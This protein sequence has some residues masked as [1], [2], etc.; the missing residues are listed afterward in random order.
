MIATGFLGYVLPYGQMSLWGELV[1]PICKLKS[2]IIINFNLISYSLCL[3]FSMPK[4]KSNKRIG[5]HNSNII[6]FIFGSL[7]GDGFA[8]KRLNSTRIHF[9]QEGSHSAYL[10]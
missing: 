4:I 6:E 8:E 9:Y 10:I 1:C 5:P 7:L 2:L 3:P